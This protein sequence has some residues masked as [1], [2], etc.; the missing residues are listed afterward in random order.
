MTNQRPT[1]LDRERFWRRLPPCSC[2]NRE[3]HETHDAAQAQAAEPTTRPTYHA[4]QHPDLGTAYRTSDGSTFA[5]ESDAQ[6][7]ADP[8]PAR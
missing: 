6:L 1:S 2:G 5:T 7:H 8:E 3:P 4:I